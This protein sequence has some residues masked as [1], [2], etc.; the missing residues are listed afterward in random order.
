M[1]DDADI[2]VDISVPP[3]PLP[4]VEGERRKEQDRR[5]ADRQGKYDRRKNRCIHCLHFKEDS[6]VG[7]GFCE[8]H[9]TSMTA[10]AFA[11]PQFENLPPPFK[12]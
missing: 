6:A 9:D 11:C 8:K 2:D 7:K 4:H 12:T 3:V 1:P 10:Y 5:Q